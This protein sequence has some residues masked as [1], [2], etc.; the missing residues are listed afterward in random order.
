ELDE[1]EEAARTA[2][3]VGALHRRVRVSPDLAA[4]LPRIVWHQDEPFAIASAFAVWYLSRVARERV[5]VALS[6]DGADELFGG[7]PWRH[8]R[9]APNQI[10]ARVPGPIRR[11]LAR[12]APADAPGV[13]PHGSKSARARAGRW[14]KAAG[15]PDSEIYGDM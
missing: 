5:T 1:G 14:L 3:A 7:Y 12:L 4:D 2:A 9:L 15:R 6:G 13:G 11:A 8:A 10:L